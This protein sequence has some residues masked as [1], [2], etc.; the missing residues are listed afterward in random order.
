MRRRELIIL[1]SGA[2]GTAVAGPLSALAPQPSSYRLG[3]I[4]PRDPFDEK[5]RFGSLLIHVLG[6]SGYTLG[7]NLTLYARGLM[8]DMHRVTQLLQDMKASKV[9]ACVVTG[10]PVALAAKR[11]DIP[12]VVAFGGGDPVAT[13]LVQ[14]L[15]RPGGSMTGISDNATQLSTKRLSL[16]KQLNPKLR[17]VAMLWNRNDLGMSKRYEASAEVAQSLD[18]IVMPLGVREPDDFKEAFAAMD[19]ETPDAILM[20]SD[21]L[22]TLNRKRVFDYAADRRIP[23]IYEYDFLVRDGGLMSYGADLDESFERAGD[24]VARIF[25]GARPADLP[26]EQPTRYPFV[27]NLKTARSSGIEL[28]PNFVALADEVIE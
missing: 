16:L 8:G 12:T 21:S 5:S 19:S 7:R 24:L 1:L 22:T 20:V 15:S 18:V 3:T 13:G 25:Q 2:T 26:F 28:P 14:S 10:F 9:D 23:A 11:V 27:I 4:G 17:R 6:N